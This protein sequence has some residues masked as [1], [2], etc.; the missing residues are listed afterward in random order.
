MSNVESFVTWVVQSAIPVW[1]KRGFDPNRS[2]FHERLD[3]KGEPLDVPYRSMVQARQIFVYAEACRAGWFPQGG[4][5]ALRALASLERDYAVEQG[6]GLAFRFASHGPAAESFDSYG[7]AF[8]LLSFAAAQKLAPSDRLIA[9]TDATVRFVED[10]LIDPVHG[11]LF[12]NP[13]AL[14]DKRQNPLMHLFEAY[15]ALEEAMPGRG[16]LKRAAALFKV[17]TSDLFEPEYGRIREHFS[18]NW[19]RHPDP[20]LADLVEPGHLFEW[21]WLLDRFGSLAKLDVSAAGSA[22]VRRGMTGVKNDGLIADALPTDPSALAEPSHRLWPHTEAIKAVGVQHRR[23][24][25]NALP[26]ADRFACALGRYFLDAPFAGGWIDRV[27]A[28]GESLSRDVPAS[29]LYHL[30]LAAIDAEATFRVERVD[31]NITVR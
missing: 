1:A 11:G 27:D 23:G 4:D 28:A 5:L 18:R 22:L 17:F 19:G 26:A 13:R 30:V 31:P 9:M 14:A 16:H 29:S 20:L 21:A 15:I 2:R 10:A 24:D 6:N 3:A 7:H 12:D 25:P 8:V